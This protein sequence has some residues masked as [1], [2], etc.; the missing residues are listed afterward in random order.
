MDEELGGINPD[1]FFEQLT[2]VRETA[3]S[4]QKTSNSNLSLFNEL[5][6]KV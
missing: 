5:R 4:A 3:Q 2:E 6:S 1:S